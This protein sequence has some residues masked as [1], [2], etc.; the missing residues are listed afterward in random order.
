MDTQTQTTFRRKA[1]RLAGI[2]GITTIVVW[3]FAAMFST[4]WLFT[5]V[6]LPGVVLFALIA[7]TCAGCFIKCPRRPVLPKLVILVLTV[8]GLYWALWAGAYYWVYYL[9]QG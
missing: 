5:F 1:W 6:Q 3:P 8:F 2:A 9:F 4:P 7:I